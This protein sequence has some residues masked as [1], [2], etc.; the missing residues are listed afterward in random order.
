MIQP[1]INDN[2]HQVEIIEKIN[3]LIWAVNNIT[4]PQKNRSRHKTVADNFRKE[5]KRLIKALTD[6][7]RTAE[8]P[9]EVFGERADIHQIYRRMVA[10]AKFALD[11]QKEE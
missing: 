10:L 2:L 9:F 3:E 8:K 6:I 4:E 11:N 7:V 5:N 1:I